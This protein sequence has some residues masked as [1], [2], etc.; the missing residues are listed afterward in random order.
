MVDGGDLANIDGIDVWSEKIPVQNAFPS[1][2]SFPSVS[3]PPR[4]TKNVNTYKMA[5][6]QQ[7]RA[8]VA[9]ALEGHAAAAGERAARR[10][11]QI[12]RRTGTG[13]TGTR[14]RGGANGYPEPEPPG[15]AAVQAAANAAMTGSQ[16][17]GSSPTAA[18]QST[19]KAANAAAA[20]HGIPENSGPVIAAVNAAAAAAG[21]PMPA[22]SSRQNTGGVQNDYL[23]DVFTTADKV[24]EFRAVLNDLRAA[25]ASEVFTREVVPD[26]AQRIGDTQMLASSITIHA[27]ETF[28]TVLFAGVAEDAENAGEAKPVPIISLSM[29]KAEPMIVEARSAKWY[30]SAL[31]MVRMLNAADAIAARY[32]KCSGLVTDTKCMVL[33]C[34]PGDAACVLDET[35]GAADPNDI[36]ERFKATVRECANVFVAPEQAQITVFAG[37]G[38]VPFIATNATNASRNVLAN[39]PTQAKQ[40]QVR[41]QRMQQNNNSSKRNQAAQQAAAQAQAQMKNAAQ[42]QAQ[43]AAQASAQA[44][45][46]QQQ[47]Q[48]QQVQQVQQHQVQENNKNSKRNAQAQMK[49]AA[50][51]ASAQAQA[52][53]K[54]QADGT[55]RAAELI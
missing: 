2:S 45:V 6:R 54:K 22:P 42:A 34:S 49:N 4:L 39:A 43:A 48:Q 33:A 53:K 37:P 41:Q 8:A 13:R 7:H 55:E 24:Q 27:D 31:A 32:G 21:V 20:V 3:S 25:P 5:S 40:Q 15:N 19:L 52:R 46:K 30:D 9:Q 18:V 29:D 47:V 17:I 14:T 28:V 16:A 11:K 12:Q 38:D 10:A 1:H 35:D 44:Q 36:A 50:Q 23:L 51:Q 26:G